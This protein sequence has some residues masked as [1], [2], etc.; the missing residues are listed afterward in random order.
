MTG[1]SLRGTVY[2][3]V[4]RVPREFA[5]LEPRA[6]VRRSL[7][8]GDLREA[9]KRGTRE[10]AA[11]LARW[12]AGLAAGGQ[13]P[14][15]EAEAVDALRKAE[16]I[17]PRT[18]G[19]LVAGPLDQLIERI[20]QVL[21]R[22]PPASQPAV[23]KAWL[24]VGPGKGEDP[25]SALLEK[26][27]KL[28]PDLIHGMSEEQKRRWRNPREKVLRDL[29]S[30]IG[31]K[32][33]V[34]TDDDDARALREHLCEQV[35]AYEINPATA[36][37]YVHYVSGMMK[38]YSEKLK[39]KWKHPFVGMTFKDS[40]SDK[41]RRRPFSTTWIMEHLSPPDALLG[42]NAEA[43]DVLLAM[44]DTGARPS[45]II[46]LLP[47]HIRLD[48][49]IPH[50]RIV[51][52]DRV[53]KNASS[54]RDLPLVGLSLEAMRRNPHGFPRYRGK[55]GWSNLVNKFLRQNCAIKD[56]QSAYSLRHS[57]EDRLLAAEAVDR[58]AADLMG[59]ATRRARYGNGAS[60]ELKHE[61]LQL[62]AI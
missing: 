49:P 14:A 12:E 51:P 13:D 2:Y 28:A 23:A 47:E 15:A 46:G 62:I 39:L 24:G 31:D 22:D 21:E 61:T 40:S 4:K 18:L 3:L 55:G 60:L 53:L 30:C 33:V 59:H 19:D 17:V 58:L 26:V 5:H 6:V 36:N 54:K 29:I 20:E 9:R 8:T 45:E 1:L 56:D 25:I 37:K 16:R 48:D 10:Q 41:R 43:R 44:V 38:V 32:K 27:Q 35:E 50:I 34:E 11:M 7:K 57:F 42:L 52:T